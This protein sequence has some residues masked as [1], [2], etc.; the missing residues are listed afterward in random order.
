M[1][2]DIMDL[3]RY[4]CDRDVILEASKHLARSNEDTLVAR[5]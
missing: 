3:F 5:Q 4:Y 1:D 2:Q